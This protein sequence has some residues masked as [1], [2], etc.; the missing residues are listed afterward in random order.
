MAGRASPT[1]A[2]DWGWGTIAALRQRFEAQVFAAPERSLRDRGSVLVCDEAGLE[3]VQSLFKVNELTDHNIP[4]VEKLCGRRRQPLPHNPVIYLISCDV[5]SAQ[6]VVDDWT[7]TAEETERAR[8]G[9]TAF[10]KPYC[11][12]HI[13]FL[14]GAA[15]PDRR[16]DE[17][18]QK[19][20]SC[21]LL[22]QNVRTMKNLGI[23][24]TCPESHMFVLRPTGDSAAAEHDQ[25]SLFD[26]QPQQARVEAKRVA[27]GIASAL[28]SLGDCP[29]VRYQ[30]DKSAC[31][32]AKLV[33]DELDQILEE[34]RTLGRS[35]RQGTVL[36][37]DRSIDPVVP[38][39]HDFHLQAFI[40]D[41]M[42]TE[43][44]CFPLNPSEP[45][46]IRV[47]VHPPHARRPALIINRD[48]MDQSSRKGVAV[49]FSEIK[50]HMQVFMVPSDWPR[51]SITD[52]FM[53]T[54]MDQPQFEITVPPE[55]IKSS[56]DATIG[57]RLS[58]TTIADIEAQG[59]AHKTGAKRD[60]EVIAL[61]DHAVAAAN[62]TSVFQ[63][64]KGTR[65]ALR[66]K[67]MANGRR[68]RW[69][70]PEDGGPPRHVPGTGERFDRLRLEPAAWWDGGVANPTKA[71]CVTLDEGAKLWC[72][73]RHRHFAKAS[74]VLRTVSEAL[75]GSEWS[76]L[77]EAGL[78]KVAELDGEML[79]KSRRALANCPKAE[80]VLLVA[81]LI[82]V[83]RLL[84]KLYLA[85][86]DHILFEQDLA[87]RDDSVSGKPGK[88][89]L[90]RLLADNSLQAHMEKPTGQL[91]A[92][93]S[94]WARR[95]DYETRIR[96]LL[97]YIASQGEPGDL[98]KLMSRIPP[99]Q[100]SDLPSPALMIKALQFLDITTVR[101]GGLFGRKAKPQ[102]RV[103]VQQEQGEDALALSRYIPALRTVAE[104]LLA[105]TDGLSQGEFP[106]TQAAPHGAS[107]AAS[108][109]SVMQSSRPTRGA[110]LATDRITQHKDPRPGQD[111]GDDGAVP[112]SLQH[113]QGP[114]N[115][116]I[117]VGG[118]S[119]AESRAISSVIADTRKTLVVGTT[120][121]LTPRGYLHSLGSLGSRARK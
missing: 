109:S 118:L 11:T 106:Y 24:F 86:Y 23:M 56:L 34:S 45:A 64:L 100:E 51:H 63:S 10:R 5:A 95:H 46:K 38:L 54:V 89:Q 67:V 116:I 21:P 69:H 49:P 85:W 82:D 62:I 96:V 102:A 105:D 80:Y 87:C 30:K 25:L 99:C 108:S 52:R 8:D 65:D 110:R 7:P 76:K 19:I 47:G 18:M 28:T 36:I 9:E 81:L 119:Y 107:S 2:P 55:A 71:D 94:A 40:H 84:G 3:Q 74:E 103:E 15:T 61:N 78:K 48:I 4:V 50:L 79:Q 33:A 113:S 77:Q 32:V 39:L 58:G 117:V 91:P 88:E 97:A 44:Q 120:S 59:I 13:F 112:W 26:L 72:R 57:A 35:A 16:T 20:A 83:S 22:A 1:P 93:G 101:K 31:N 115:Y 104:R 75:K 29:T 17:V 43:A 73:L 27:A 60:F 14:D 42:P 121:L 111:E 12:A 6:G 98:A 90:E 92:F 66:V 53:C 68:V 114:R 41:M 70:E 37:L